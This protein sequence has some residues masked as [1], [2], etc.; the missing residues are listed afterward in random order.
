VYG[1]NHSIFLNWTLQ[2]PND[3]PWKGYNKT[4]I[5]RSQTTFSFGP[6]GIRDATSLLLVAGIPQPQTAHNTNISIIRLLA[7]AATHTV[8]FKGFNFGNMV[9]VVKVTYRSL[10][11]DGLTPKQYLCVVKTVDHDILSCET[12]GGEYVGDYS[13]L[14]EVFGQVSA[15]GQ[16]ILRFVLP[17]AIDSVRGCINLTNKTTCPGAGGLSVGTTNCS[18]QGGEMLTIHG[19]NFTADLVR[20]KTYDWICLIS[21][22]Y[23]LTFI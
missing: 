6:P 2:P 10:P 23:Y 16:D 1:A 15:L 22:S 18:T 8:S 19:Q 4:Y 17:P 21:P 7:G 11:V 12:S 20:S 9:S 3:T 13:F 14:V 5:S